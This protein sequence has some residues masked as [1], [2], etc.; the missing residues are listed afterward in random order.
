MAERGVTGPTSTS[1]YF[2]TP[3]KKRRDLESA[4][5]RQQAVAH[6]MTHLPSHED[7]ATGEILLVLVPR[8]PVD[9]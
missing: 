3:S 8:S 5:E 2:F 6:F 1:V 4:S 7:P 9:L